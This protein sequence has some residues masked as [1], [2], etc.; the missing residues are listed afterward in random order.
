MKSLTLH[1]VLGWLLVIVTLALIGFYIPG[2]DAT[3]GESYLIFF[4]HFPSAI[5]CLNFFVLA[6]VLSGL[7][8]TKRTPELEFRYDPSISQGSDILS[9]LDSLEIQPAGDET[10]EEATVT[11]RDVEPE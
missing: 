2:R 1:F 7:Y 8:L 3:I 5:N 9:L 11:N 4:F 6:G 10:A